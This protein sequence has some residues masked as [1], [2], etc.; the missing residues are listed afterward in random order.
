MKNILD[1][2]NTPEFSIEE[3]RTIDFEKNLNFINYETVR[4]AIWAFIYNTRENLDLTKI[5]F[6][7]LEISLSD[8]IYNAVFTLA[9]YSFLWNEFELQTSEGEI[10]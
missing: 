8:F 6:N 10:K 2:R 3:F 7:A 1:N 4:E 5:D 9:Q